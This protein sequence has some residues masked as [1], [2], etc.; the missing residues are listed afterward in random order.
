MQIRIEIDVK[1]D[2]LRRFLG[3]P[4][5]AGLQEELIEFLRD[6][7]GAEGNLDAGLL[8]RGNLAL[9]KRS[10]TFRR[11]WYGT[12]AAAARTQAEAAAAPARAPATGAVKPRQAAKKPKKPRVVRQARAR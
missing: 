12:G 6:R 3:L 1:P 9:L 5:V 11:W 4:D 8:L 7:F 2:E 10:P